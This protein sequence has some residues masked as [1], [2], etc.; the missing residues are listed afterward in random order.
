MNPE[1]PENEPQK[2]PEKDGE[3]KERI[4]QSMIEDE[5]KTSYL[6]YSMSVIVGRALPDA[7]DG[8]KPVHRRI[9]FAMNDMGMQHNKPFKKSARIVGEVLGKY[10]PH[11]D[12]AVYDALVRMA[13]DFSL[14]Y[15]LIQGQG[16]F[17]S[18]D[19]DNAAAMRYTEAR[20]AKIAEEILT[21]IDKE[22]VNFTPNFDGSLNE[23][24]VLPSKLPNLMING[25]S[26]IAVGM[27]TNIPPHNIKEIIEG[28]MALIDNPDISIEELMKYIKGPDFP[29]AGIISGMNGIKETYLTG[30]GKITVKAKAEIEKHKDR[31]RII[32]TEMPYQVNKAMLIEEIADNVKEKRIEGVSDIRDESDRDG[33]RVVIELKRDANSNVTLN[34]LF[35]YTRMTYTFGA[36]MLALVNNE[37]K[38]LNLKQMLQNYV[39]HRQVVVRRRTQFDLKKA[40]ERAHIIEGLIIALNNIDDVVRKIKAS[41]TVD[42][43]K[44]MLMDDYKLSETQAK[45]ILDMKLQKLSSLEQEKIREEHKGLLKMME[46]LKSIL[47]SE[48][49]ILGIIKEE[50]VEIREKYGDERRTAIESIQEEDLVIED[51]IK[52]EDV[53]VTISHQGYI[54]RTKLSEYKQQLRGGKGVI[55]AGTKEED[56]VEHIFITSTHSYIL[57]FTNKGMVYWLK[58]HKIPET[59]RQAKG[60]AIVNLMQLENGEKIAAFVPVKE[61]DDKHYLMLAT[62]KGLVK[63]T[64]MMEYS[65]PRQTGIIGIT[66]EEGDNLVNALLTDGESQVMLATSDGMA[67]KFHEQDAR[68]IGRTSKGVRGITLKG[69]DVVVGM[70]KAIDDKTLLTVTENGYGKRTMISKYR[71][72]AR[73]GIGVIN[74]QCTERNGKVVA[75]KTVDDEDDIM[76]ISK[77]GITIR[78]P[79]KGISVI[80]RNTQGVRLMKL[81]AGDNVIDAASIVKE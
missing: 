56:F 38:Y 78:S 34:Q 1:K 23:P 42:N 80:G 81:E 64:N 21:D 73:G 46:E 44:D 60:K 50:A 53:V 51:L 49:R 71:I 30:R 27:A 79:V 67:V 32:L 48:E 62:R 45:A 72:I 35:N 17:G 2:G 22:T 74:I 57:F 37:P 77:N 70:V 52:D 75:V 54:K 29:T 19:G 15:P 65:R 9:L 18:I 16:N 11:G 55:A 40:E 59:S 5:M 63:K 47:A 14:R 43:A 58:V 10:H 33:I 31:E 28:I 8:L 6:D 12:T 69:D 4:I 39:L 3:I 36:I 13:Q 24:L 76:L 20:L 7:R 26:G 66:L 68:P 25:S 61:F 41:K